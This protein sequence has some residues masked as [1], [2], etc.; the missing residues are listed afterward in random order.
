[1]MYKFA[2]FVLSI[3]HDFLVVARVLTNS[4]IIYIISKSMRLKFF[5]LVLATSLLGLFSVYHPLS[6]NADTFNPENVSNTSF[7]SASNVNPDLE[8]DPQGNLHAIWMVNNNEGSGLHTY[9]STKPVGGAWSTPQLISPLDVSAVFPSMAMEN[10][11]TIH[12]VWET[13]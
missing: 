3:I 2:F 1:M 7:G 9:Y 6:I 11:G 13:P 5:S 10:E 4:A 8:I 12:V